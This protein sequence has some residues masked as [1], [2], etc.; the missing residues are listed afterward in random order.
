MFCLTLN[1]IYSLYMISLIHHKYWPAMKVIMYLVVINKNMLMRCSLV[2]RM[3]FI[4][5]TFVSWRKKLCC[6]L[7]FRYLS[8]KF[9][10]WN[11]NICFHMSVL[12]AHNILVLCLV[13]WLCRY[14]TQARDIIQNW[15]EV[16]SLCPWT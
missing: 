16:I 10:F 13:Q 5:M 4:T 6:P 11:H 15:T 7:Y 12:M 8:K 3:C 1:F 14:F 2:L 9:H